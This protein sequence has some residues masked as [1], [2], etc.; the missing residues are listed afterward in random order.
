MG[1]NTVELTVSR[2]KS[3]P[4]DGRSLDIPHNTRRSGGRSSDHLAEERVLT[5]DEVTAM[6]SDKTVWGE[7]AFKDKHHDHESILDQLKENYLERVQT[8]RTI[9]MERR[10]TRLSIST[11]VVP[12]IHPKEGLPN[13]SNERSLFS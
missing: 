11:K 13:V 2:Y 4:P 6:F 5:G 1:Q 12:I 10:T 8:N 3:L 9:L 7:H